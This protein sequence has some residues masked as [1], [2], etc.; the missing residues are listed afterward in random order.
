[1]RRDSHIDW[2][3]LFS[4]CCRVSDVISFKKYILSPDIYKI[5]VYLVG[6]FI[7]GGANNSKK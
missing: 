7:S 1:M 2:C 3:I 4:A 6:V 5:H